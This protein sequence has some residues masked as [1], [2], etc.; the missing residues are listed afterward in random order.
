L[1]IFLCF[2]SGIIF[3]ICYIVFLRLEPSFY[4]IVDSTINVLLWIATILIMCLAGKPKRFFFQKQIF[5]LSFSN[6]IQNNSII[7]NRSKFLD[8]QNNYY[9]TETSHLLAN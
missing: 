8:H 6:N 4:L 1:A 5:F 3:V 9:S 2:F 7:K